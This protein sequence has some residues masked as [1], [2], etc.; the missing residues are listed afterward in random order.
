MLKERYAVGKTLLTKESVCVLQKFDE[1]GRAYSYYTRFRSEWLCDLWIF[2][3]L[4]KQKKNI[5]SS[6]T[7]F[8]FPPNRKKQKELILFTDEKPDSLAIAVQS[9]PCI[10]F[11]RTINNPQ[12]PGLKS[13]EPIFLSK[14]EKGG[15]DR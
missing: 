4:N 10:W 11:Y 15:H 7:L 8:Y 2:L 1:Q 6:D 5:N 3:R 14:I 12:H 9:G 13:V